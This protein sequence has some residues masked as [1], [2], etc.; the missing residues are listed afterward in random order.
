MPF[1]REQ[2]KVDIAKVMS[3]W[4]ASSH[5][6][7]TWWEM[8]RFSADAFFLVGAY[9]QTLQGDICMDPFSDMEVDPTRAMRLMGPIRE[10]RRKDAVD[11]LRR[12]ASL[13]D[14]IGMRISSETAKEFSEDLETKSLAMS[15][16]STR[17]NDLR[18]LIAKEMQGRMFMYVP[19]DR[20]AYFDATGAGLFGNEVGLRF[21]SAKF[22]S[23]EAGNCLAAGRSTACVFHLMRVLEIGL[24]VLAKVFGVS[25]QH[26]NWEP[27][28]REIEAKI[29]DMHKDPNWTAKADWK[30]QREF[31]AQAASH[32]GILKD[33]WRNY[34]M[35]IRAKYTEEEAKRIFGNTKDFMQKL[36]VRLTE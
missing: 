9:L 29:R 21:P 2:E 27:A 31:Y 24:D 28:I 33:A 4:E 19:L 17:I 36:A 10:D 7:I 13:C 14:S 16:V 35:H 30:Q 34:T 3:P 23:A 12:I 20:A 26:T 32:F 1:G 11:T 8:E 15:I 18:E 25:M 22:D 5:S 6:L